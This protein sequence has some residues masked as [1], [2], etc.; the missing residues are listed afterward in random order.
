[1]FTS[2]DRAEKS[3]LTPQ[4]D[5]IKIMLRSA[6]WNINFSESEC[7]VYLRLIISGKDMPK[8]HLLFELMEKYLIR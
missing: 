2:W 3:G 8:F 1:M 5:E 4:L 6:M 7:A